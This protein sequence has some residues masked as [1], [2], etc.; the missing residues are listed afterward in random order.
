MMQCFNV[1]TLNEKKIETHYRTENC[2]VCFVFKLFVNGQIGSYF[3]DMFVGYS[4]SWITDRQ[5]I[6]FL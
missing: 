5:V 4:G 6:I 1:F 2:F 3:D